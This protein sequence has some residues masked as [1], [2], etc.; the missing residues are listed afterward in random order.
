MAWDLKFEQGIWLPQ[1]GWWLDARLPV[2]RS[3][4][5]HAHF[6]HLAGHKE[7]LCSAGTARLMRTR[8]PGR[9]I[10]HV[11]PFGHT[12]ALTADCAVTLHPA[13]HIFG[14]AQALLDH[15]EHGTHL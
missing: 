1:I 10:E 15:D 9:R 8:M 12:E 2:D 5:S 11:L 3:F 7:I 4:V 6:D 14:S 13:G